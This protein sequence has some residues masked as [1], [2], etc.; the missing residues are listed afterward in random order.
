MIKKKKNKD[1]STHNVEIGTLYD[2]N[3]NLVEKNIEIL[4]EEEIDNKRTL[5]QDFISKTNNQYYMLL[6]ND[7]KDYTVFHRNKNK[8]GQYWDVCE[9]YVG[10]RID[11]ILTKECLPNRGDIKSIELTKNKDAIEIWISIEQESFC[12][13]FFPYDNAAIEC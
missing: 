2:V 4:T 5:I 3:K 6:C 11:K 12:Y 1:K 8:N 9:G 13:Y 10:D 7:K